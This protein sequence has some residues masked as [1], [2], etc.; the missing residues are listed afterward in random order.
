MAKVNTT[1][2]KHPFVD[3]HKKEPAAETTFVQ[4]FVAWA[5]SVFSGCFFSACVSED[6]TQKDE[7]T[8]LPPRQQPAPKGQHNNMPRPPYYGGGQTRRSPHSLPRTPPW[9]KKEQSPEVESSENNSSSDFL[10]TQESKFI[11]KIQRPLN[12]NEKIF[13][14]KIIEE[15]K[16]SKAKIAPGRTLSLI[17][18]QD[19]TNTRKEMSNDEKKFRNDVFL[20]CCGSNN[21]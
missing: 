2:G 9:Q 14:N 13:W 6:T 4:K 17:L 7:K 20:Y 21:Q 12:P 1:T 11:S 18:H 3:M 19:K 15:F 5:E 16:Q 10:E 8:P